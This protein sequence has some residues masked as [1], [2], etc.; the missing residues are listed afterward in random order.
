[1]W[2][3]RWG[4]RGCRSSRRLTAIAS[5]RARACATLGTP[6]RAEGLKDSLAHYGNRGF[7]I[8]RGDAGLG[9]LAVGVA[10]DIRH[11]PRRLLFNCAV[12]G[13][14]ARSGDLLKTIGPTLVQL[15]N[16]AGR[17]VGLR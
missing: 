13:Y 10:S 16:L 12:P 11:G 17:Q 3:Q 9:V 2:K 6:R 8:K 5:W 4:V 15:V 1:M 7:A 14:R